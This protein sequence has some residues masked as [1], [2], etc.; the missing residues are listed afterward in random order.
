MNLKPINDYI[1]F[2]YNLYIYSSYKYES[3][4]FYKIQ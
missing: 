4:Y 1:Y 3:W 2:H